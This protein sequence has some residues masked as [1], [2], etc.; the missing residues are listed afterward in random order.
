MSLSSSSS[1]ALDVQAN[2]GSPLNL[3]NA[4]TF[5]LCYKYPPLYIPLLLSSLLPLPIS[6][7]PCFITNHCADLPRIRPHVHHHARPPILRF[8]TIS[9]LQPRPADLPRGRQRCP[10]RGV[11]TRMQ[12][13][14]RRGRDRYRKVSRR[15]QGHHHR[16][17]QSRSRTLHRAPPASQHPVFLSPPTPPLPLLHIPTSLIRAPQPARAPL[18]LPPPPPYNLPRPF[19]R[20]FVNST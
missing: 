12:D 6:S 10:Y 8:L 4:S 7:Y 2:H 18:L 3:L 15:G 13:D 11:P 19:S 20:Y 17:T 14:P 9:S 1:L 5:P 16:G